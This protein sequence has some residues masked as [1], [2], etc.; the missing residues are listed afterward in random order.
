[1]T[2]IYSKSLKSVFHLKFSSLYGQS[3]SVDFIPTVSPP[4]SLSSSH[5]CLEDMLDCWENIRMEVSHF[6]KPETTEDVLT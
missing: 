4:L 3:C 1:M 6:D 5:K 2:A